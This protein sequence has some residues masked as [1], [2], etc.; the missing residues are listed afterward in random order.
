MKLFTYIFSN[1]DEDFSVEASPHYRI[2]ACVDCFFPIAFLFDMKETKDLLSNVAYIVDF[3]RDTWLEYDIIIK[4]W[5]C[6]NCIKAI[7]LTYSLNKPELLILPQNEI[8]INP[9]ST[10]S[11]K[12]NNLH[13]MWD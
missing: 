12:F 3:E 5:R 1:G 11:L 9:I 7:K 4:K 2:A 13:V 6:R 10:V 8:Y